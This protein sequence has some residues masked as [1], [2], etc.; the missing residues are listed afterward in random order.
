MLEKQKEEETKALQRSSAIQEKLEHKAQRVVGDTHRRQAELRDKRDLRVKRWSV[1]QEQ[2][3]S[4]REELINY[5]DQISQQIDNRVEEMKRKRQSEVLQRS[6]R[7]QKQYDEKLNKFQLD[8]SLNLEQMRNSI[9]FR[10]RTKHDHISKLRQDQNQ[11][12]QER[13]NR[14]F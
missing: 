14:R 11:E 9:D 3:N 2:L 8:K 1:H 4:H 7:K 6:Q 5:K 12:V 10:D 13:G